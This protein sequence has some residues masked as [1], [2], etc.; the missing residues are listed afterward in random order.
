[1][2]PMLTKWMT[3]CKGFMQFHKEGAISIQEWNKGMNM[4]IMADRRPDVKKLMTQKFK[5]MLSELLD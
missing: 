1:M 5:L 2:H 4:Y 3:I